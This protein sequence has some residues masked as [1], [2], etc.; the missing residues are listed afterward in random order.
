M[1][2]V[3]AC[4]G[5]AGL[6]LVIGYILPHVAKARGDRTTISVERPVDG[7]KREKKTLRV[8][9]KSDQE[10]DVDYSP[11]NDRPAWVVT[12]PGRTY[13]AVEE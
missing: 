5:C 9:R 7:W 10:G 3:A 4:L 11:G 6:G 13:Y 2:R 1:R 12:T 8:I